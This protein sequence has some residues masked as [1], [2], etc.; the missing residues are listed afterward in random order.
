MLEHPPPAKTFPDLLFGRQPAPS[1]FPG[2]FCFPVSDCLLLLL[3]SCFSH[4]LPLT[5]CFHVFQAVQDIPSGVLPSHDS[6]NQQ[7]A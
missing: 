7:A 2:Q 6:G 3:A 4:L 1:S 5:R